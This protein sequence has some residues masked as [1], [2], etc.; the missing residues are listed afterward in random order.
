MMEKVNEVLKANGKRELTMDELDQVV[1]GSCQFD[2]NTNYITING[3][4]PMP[5]GQFCNMMYAMTKSF[6]LDTALLFLK[7][8]V[9]FQCSE[10]AEGTGMSD[11]AFM[12]V[13]LA[14]FDKALHGSG[15]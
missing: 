1:G 13:I 6:G 3:G 4:E 15:Y 11:K 7:D 5:W 9:G 14:R 10:M 2:P 12:G 8:S